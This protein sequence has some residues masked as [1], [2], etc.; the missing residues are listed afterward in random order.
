MAI[1]LITG[2]AN[3][4][5]ARAVLERLHTHAARG[6]EP[7]L[8][9]PTR[10]DVEHYL[11]ELAGSGAVMGVRVERFAGL[12]GELARRAG[13]QE[14]A[15]G[16]TAR[17]RIV[18][19]LAE[20]AGE[21]ASEGLV[22]ALQDLFAELR[23]QRVGAARFEQALARAQAGGGSAGHAGLGALFASYS[24]TLERLGLVDAEQRTMR[25]LDALRERPSLWGGTPVLF[26]GFDDLTTLQLDAIETLGRLV[27]AP[28]T[29]S[30]AYEG[31]RAAFAGRAAS[32]QALRPLAH[33]HVQLA[34]RA[35]HYARASRRALGHL[36]RSLF[37]A[38]A[39]RVP[40]GPAL[41]LLEGGGERA[42]LELIAGEL[43][44]LLAQGVPAEQIAV[45]V[46]PGGTDLDLL[47]DVFAV[48]GVPFRLVRRRRFADTA[49]G[50]ALIGL[51]R[52]VAREDGVVEGT[53][54]DLLRWLRAPG[55]LRLE[56]AEGP[57][58]SLA[59]RLELAARRAGVLDAAGAR[60][61]WE[62]R[63]WPLE[64]IERLGEAQGA[65]A[66]ALCALAARELRWLFR[67]PWRGLA[68]V[69]AA[70]ERD[71]AAALAAGERALA[72]LRE[73]ARIAPELAPAGAAELA[74]CLASVEFVGAGHRTAPASD[75]SP[76]DARG[77]RPAQA[78]VAVL[79]PLQLRARR[80]RA[81]FVCGLQEGAFPARAG[82][83]PLLDD[84]ER[85]RLAE[86]AGLRLDQ[87]AGHSQA[88]QLAS[89][90]Y[91]L[92]AALS[93]PQERLYLSWHT[94]DDDAEGASRSLFVDDVC[95]LFEESLES[96]RRRRALG[97]LPAEPGEEGALPGGRP[98]G[99][100]QARRRRGLGDA[101]VLGRLAELVWSPSSLERW[102]GCPM[103]WFVEKVL[104]PGD[105]EPDPEPLAR[106]ALAH[107]ALKETFDALRAQTGSAKL[108]P[109]RL[110][111]ARELLRAALSECEREHPL[112]GPPERQ[113]SVRR[114]LR[115][116]LE[117]YLAHAAASSSPLQ[118]AAFELG[119]G[120][121]AGDERGEPSEL[122]ALELAGLRLRGRVDRVDTDGQGRAVVYDYKGA[123]VPPG[124]RWIKDGRVQVALYMRAAE[125]LMGV[126]AAGGFYQP[127]SG[128]DLRARG[129]LDGEAGIELDCVRQDVLEHAELRGLLDDALA[130]AAAAA[131]E[132]RRGEL[133][134]RPESCAYRGGC[135]FPSICRCSP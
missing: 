109:A 95:D 20:R 78:A 99:V 44:S 1:K 6:E 127:L 118:P 66:A 60:A 13:V 54:A 68:P 73:L 51:L 23:V 80:V 90:R 11:R 64:Q 75:H 120:I 52:C 129:V 65:G 61:L 21:R 38:S 26:Y 67:A 62:E 12:G 102:I 4:G 8:V 94:A 132:A 72:E 63:N 69:L 110:E 105:F 108:T 81:L 86:L 36:E 59:D 85:R 119:F 82:A 122:P 43:L 115:A 30:L 22:R 9:V 104:R 47:E 42:E 32:F 3:A 70:G 25:A 87:H 53:L 45:L 107:A 133:E 35:E 49:V 135:M 29:V 93:R 2:P 131:G 5:K 101:R 103:S 55:V 40:A 130:L 76:Q 134:G 121:A 100:R 84:G 14:A 125:E 124:A 28:V 50:G 111:R 83:Q 113:L 126:Q 31:G 56:G 114:R 48:A 33:E 41:Q 96:G 106:G 57:G 88:A 71:E 116:D 24:R 91:L 18:A 15:L 17:E 123:N 89:E 16:A 74:G 58:P 92:Y 128:D 112:T 117:R 97:A 37:E 27:D 7:L 46:R 79:D 10:A 98:A 39:A 19:A 34:A 77:A